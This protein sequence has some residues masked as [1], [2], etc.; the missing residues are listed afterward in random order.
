MI[1]QCPPA[2]QAGAIGPFPRSAGAASALL[3]FVQMGVAAG[4]GAVLG[5]IGSPSPLPMTLMIPMIHQ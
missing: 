2:A 4:V 3:G 1:G 5:V